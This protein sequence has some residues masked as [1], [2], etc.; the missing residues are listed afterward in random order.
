M[1]LFL[2]AALMVAAELLVLAFNLLKANLAD[3][4]ELS[5]RRLLDPRLWLSRWEL[6]A[7]LAACAAWFLVV[8]LA[9]E[10]LSRATSCRHTA[11]AY[12]VMIYAM[13][14][15]FL[16]VQLVAFALL[17]GERIAPTDWLHLLV[18]GALMLAGSYIMF[19]VAGRWAG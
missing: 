1:T 18:A 6:P 4:V 10:L 7:C 16:Y 14:S 3:A 2:A 15:L 19:S 9:T 12:S 8:M 17:R 5:P 13:H 11:S